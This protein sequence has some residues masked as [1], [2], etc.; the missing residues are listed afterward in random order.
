M[1]VEALVALREG[2]YAVEIVDGN[3]QRHYIGVTLGLF[4]DGMVEIT[5]DG[6]AEGQKVV[7]PS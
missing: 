3:A 1:P 2:G 6:L 7:V 4:Q 5:G